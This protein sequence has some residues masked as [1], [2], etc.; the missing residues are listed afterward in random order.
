[1]KQHAE[2]MQR[3]M[4]LCEHLARASDASFRIREHA[5]ELKRAAEE[6]AESVPPERRLM[7]RIKNPALRATLTE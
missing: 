1:M 2:R 3:I 6:L 5:E 4:E 7:P